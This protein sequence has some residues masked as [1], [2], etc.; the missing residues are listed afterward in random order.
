MTS[1]F[2]GESDRHYSLARIA[3]LALTRFSVAEGD[4]QNV[5]RL[6]LAFSERTM[7]RNKPSDSR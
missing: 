7:C 4:E 2:V 6:L 5:R 3:R 1:A